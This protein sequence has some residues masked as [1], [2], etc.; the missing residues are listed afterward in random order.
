MKIFKNKF[1]LYQWNQIHSKQ[2]IGFVPTVGALHRGHLSLVKAAKKECDQVV[3]SIF[4]NKLQF[5]AN[6]DFNQYPRLIEEDIAQLK[7]EQVDVL[8]APH[9]TEI[10]PNNI[11]YDILYRYGI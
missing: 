11:L 9:Q 1:E 6:E 3:V 5:G 10:Y 4:I 7:K 8:F 2:S